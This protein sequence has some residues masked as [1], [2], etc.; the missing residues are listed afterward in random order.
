MSPPSPPS[1]HNPGFEGE[2]EPEPSDIP[3][4]RS[5][6][7][8]AGYVDGITAAKSRSTQEGFD[9]GYP[10]GAAS[11]AYVGFLRGVLEGVLAAG[12]EK[13]EDGERRKRLRELLG[14]LRAELGLEVVAAGLMGGEGAGEGDDEVEALRRSWLERV[15]TEARRSG[16]DLGNWDRIGM[17]GGSGG[18]AGE[19]GEAG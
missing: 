13:W 2:P 6:H 14:R 9:E 17:D 8:K 15:E 12:G 11:G 7:S 10:L 19:V 3:R 4:L 16:V 5:T 18:S 1:P